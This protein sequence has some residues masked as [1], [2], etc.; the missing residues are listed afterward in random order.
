M[1]SNKETWLATKR[2]GGLDYCWQTSLK[3]QLNMSL[4]LLMEDILHHLTRVTLH[5]F[6]DI[7][8]MN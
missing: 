3:L 5:E 7:L 1:D 2:H 8:H 6:G 4:I